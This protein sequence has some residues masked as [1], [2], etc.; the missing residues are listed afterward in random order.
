MMLLQKELDNIKTVYLRKQ[1]T[2]PK[3][4]VESA[5]LTTATQQS[6]VSETNV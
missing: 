1:L 2:T 5:I 4:N 3:H 6:D